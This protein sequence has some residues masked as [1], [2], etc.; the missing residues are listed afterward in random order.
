[1][2]TRSAGRKTRRNDCSDFQISGNDRL[3]AAPAFPLLLAAYLLSL[4]C[5]QFALELRE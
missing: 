5:S 4:V 3:E 1:V 2:R